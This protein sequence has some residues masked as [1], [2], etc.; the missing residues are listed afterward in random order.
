[1][2]KSDDLRQNFLAY[3]KM[4]AR[5]ESL[6]FINK[7]FT[8]L[9]LYKKVPLTASAAQ[10]IAYTINTLSGCFDQYCPSC[11]QDANFRF[12]V[13]TAYSE[14]Q[15]KLAMSI[16]GPGGNSTVTLRDF[17]KIAICTRA[18]HRQIYHYQAHDDGLVKV[19]QFPSMPDISL[20]HLKRYKKALPADDLQALRTS[21][22]LHAHGV[23]AGAFVYLRRIFE[24]Q[25]ESARQVG[26]A[27]SQWDDS[28]FSSLRMGERIQALKLHLPEVLVQNSSL[29]GILSEHIHS[30]SEEACLENFEAWSKPTCRAPRRT[31]SKQL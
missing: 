23:G 2:D 21:I 20:G 22:G 5:A 19:G 14:G 17:S 9:P 7:W 30:L 28:T 29:Y 11:L 8:N 10:G 24:G 31:W 1:M 12:S 26:S 16:T 6:D 18:N 25:V 4:N 13:D 15:R 3:N 27:D